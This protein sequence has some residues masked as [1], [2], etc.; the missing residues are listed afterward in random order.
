MGRYFPTDPDVLGDE[1]ELEDKERFRPGLD[2]LMS[3]ESDAGLLCFL[4]RLLLGH[5]SFSLIQLLNLSVPQFPH[6]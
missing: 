2:C 1:K 5:D 4:L 6:L 3:L